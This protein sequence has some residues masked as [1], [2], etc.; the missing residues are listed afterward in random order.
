MGEAAFLGKKG[1]FGGRKIL[2]ILISWWQGTI[3]V[4][5]VLHSKLPWLHKKI[6]SRMLWPFTKVKQNVFSGRL[7]SEGEEFRDK[8]HH[9]KNGKWSGIKSLVQ[10]SWKE[11][12][13]RKKQGASGWL[14][15][16]GIIYDG[17][18]LS[19]STLNHPHRIY[20]DESPCA[21]NQGFYW[22]PKC[23]K[24]EG[25]DIYWAKMASD[26]ADNQP[27]SLPGYN[28]SC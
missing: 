19:P 15:I 25:N 7:I 4:R 9:Q 24:K 1:F 12:G 17:S 5:D 20:T 21:K 6:K 14:E 2:L 11:K 22:L 16:K 10:T 18:I 27:I 23:A 13:K 28:F 26:L 8:S 3:C